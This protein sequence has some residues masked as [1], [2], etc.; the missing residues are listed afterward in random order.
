MK[1]IQANFITFM[2]LGSPSMG[3]ILEKKTPTYFT[4]L[5]QIMIMN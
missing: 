1:T 4:L 5:L 3:W 2:P